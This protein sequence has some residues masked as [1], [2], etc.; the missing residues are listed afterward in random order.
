MAKVTKDMSWWGLIHCQ[1]RCDHHSRRRCSTHNLILQLGNVGGSSHP[2]WTSLGGGSQ[3]D[4]TCR[5]SHIFNKL[6]TKKKKKKSRIWIPDWHVS[7][8]NI[9]LPK[10]CSALNMPVWREMTEQIHWRESQAPRVVCVWED[11]KPWG[12]WDTTCGHKAKGITSSVARERERRGK[13]KRS[14]IIFVVGRTRD[15]H[16]QSHEHYNYLTSNVHKSLWDTRWSS[17]VLFWARMYTIFEWTEL[18]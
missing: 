2:C 11:L 3:L 13:R 10:L 17:Y 8:F 9:H 6:A 4:D 5:H 7:M 15:G 14:M 16:R 18:R 1:A 12:A